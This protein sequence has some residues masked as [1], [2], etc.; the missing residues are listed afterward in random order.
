MTPRQ[1]RPDQF[2]RPALATATGAIAATSPAPI[3]GSLWPTRSGSVSPALDTK[4]RI[5]ST[6][7]PG[8]SKYSSLTVSPS[9]L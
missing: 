6:P 2:G 8:T 7:I 5:G 4:K 3:T 1:N 9:S